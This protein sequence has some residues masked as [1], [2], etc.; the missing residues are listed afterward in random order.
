MK[1][2]STALVA[3]ALLVGCNSNEVPLKQ[4]R[5]D[6]TFTMT[7]QLIDADKITDKCNSLG[8][9]SDSNGCA[10]FDTVSKVCTIYVMPQ[11]YQQDEERLI[12]IGHETWH[13]RF[14]QWHD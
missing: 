1:I 6:N 7:V 3:L 9:T 5:D 14:G 8:T 11:R 10:T 12:I 2:I 4:T 13:C